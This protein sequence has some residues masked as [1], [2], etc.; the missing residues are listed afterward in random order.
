MPSWNDNATK[1]SIVDF[2]EQAT[3]EGSEG[4]IPPAERIAVFDNDGTLWCEQ[5]AY[6]QLVF[7]I[8]RIKAMAE[9]H[10][11]WKNE[12]PYKSVLEGDMA[13][14]KKLGKPGLA[15][16]IAATHS[17]MSVDEFRSIV[18]EWI[19]SARHP[20]TGLLYTEMTYQPMVE[21]LAFL[22]ANGFK[23]YI[24]T[25]GGV[26]FVR[27][28]C[29][30]VYGIPPEQVVGSRGKYKFDQRYGQPV[31]MKLPQID[32]IDDGPGKPVGIQQ[33][34]G[35]RPVIA[36]GNSDGDLQMLQWAANTVG[37]GMAILIH[38]TDA[39]REYAYDRDSLIGRSDKALDEAEKHGWLI[40]DMR[41]DW[42]KIFP[43]ETLD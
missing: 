41:R 2:V 43:R 13:S 28:W 5:P 39:T 33:V 10:P 26:D 4:F 14:L 22:R 9:A 8:D 31:L 30:E 24:V 40:V 25:G 7:A 15:K 16:I 42:N 23:T 6:V 34:I 36:G 35:R 11:E 38:H 3:T 21:L 32:L 20:E 1:Q 12:E 19:A 29:E 27:A 17:G 37:P 18:N